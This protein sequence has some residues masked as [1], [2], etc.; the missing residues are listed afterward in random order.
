MDSYILSA[1]VVLIYYLLIG[2]FIADKYLL[3][4]RMLN[5]HRDNPKDVPAGTLMYITFLWFFI[6]LDNLHED[7]SKKPKPKT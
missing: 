7:R 5:K 6:A 2:I 1:A 4:E 3:R